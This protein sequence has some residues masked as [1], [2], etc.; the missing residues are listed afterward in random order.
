[1]SVEH[2]KRIAA[3]TVTETEVLVFRA[4]DF[5]VDGVLIASAE[6]Q[7]RLSRVAPIAEERDGRLVMLGDFP[8][9][10]HLH[11]TVGATEIVLDLTDAVDHNGIVPLI[12]LPEGMF[13][14][15]ESIPEA[16][17]FY[18]SLGF[19]L[20]PEIPEDY[21][22]ETDDPLSMT[23]APVT[24]VVLSNAPAPAIPED[25]KAVLTEAMA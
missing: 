1:M 16:N 23:A 25:V 22:E 3:V 18:T 11:F 21:D 17:G 14:T 15:V 7:E 6:I 12:V 2:V 8:V 24:S 9:G 19:D 10:T 4:D 5:L 20:E 13:M